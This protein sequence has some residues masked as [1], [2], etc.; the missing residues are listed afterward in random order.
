VSTGDEKQDQTK[1]DVE[2]GSGEAG[3]K[4]VTTVSLHKS[5]VG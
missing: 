3:A 4:E 1:E 2:S 5:V